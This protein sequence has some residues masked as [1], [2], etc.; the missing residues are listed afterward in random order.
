MGPCNRRVLAPVIVSRAS[1][2]LM[3][4]REKQIRACTRM[5]L[6]RIKPDGRDMP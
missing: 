5:S 3:I 2:Y 6:C 4:Y 1:C